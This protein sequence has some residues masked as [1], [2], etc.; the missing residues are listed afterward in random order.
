VFTGP[1]RHA[2]IEP[3]FKTYYNI[4]DK[5]GLG[6]EYYSSLGT[7]AKIANIHIQQPSPWFVSRTRIGE[8]W[9]VGT[10]ARFGGKFIY[11]KL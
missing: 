8:T 3:Q 7:F 4:Q 9:R 6:I 1:G 2:Q 5:F 11:I 10:P